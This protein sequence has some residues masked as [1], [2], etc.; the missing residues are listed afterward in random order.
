M[1]RQERR[2]EEATKQ[3]G[4]RRDKRTQVNQGQETSGRE[5]LIKVLKVISQSGLSELFSLN[6]VGV[7]ELIGGKQSECKL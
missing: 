5:Q 6:H 7:N 1:E 3:R 4:R 2:N